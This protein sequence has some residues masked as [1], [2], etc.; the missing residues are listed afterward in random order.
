MVVM[1][2]RYGRQEPVFTTL[3]ALDEPAMSDGADCA[4]LFGSYGVAFMP[5]Q[6]QELGC[7]L[8]MKD[9]GTKAYKT[10][11]ISK[12]RQNGK[13]F[14]A[15]FYALWCASVEGK[16]VLFSAHLGTTVR[17]FYKELEDFI[18][19]NSDFLKALKPGRSSLYRAAGSEGI[20]FANGGMIEFS[21]RTAGGGRGATYDLV[22]FDEAQ[23]LTDAQLEAVKPTMMA[24]KSG[25]SQSIYLGTPPNDEAQ[26]TVFARMHDKCHAGNAD[27]IL[28]MEWSVPEITDPMDKEAW[29]QTNP[30]LGYRVT[31]S[32]ILDAARD[33]S[34]EGF[35]REIL[36][37]WQPVINRTQKINYEQWTAL[38]SKD[39]PDWSVMAYA[40]KFSADGT[41]GAIA[42]CFRPEDGTPFVVVLRH[43]STG[44]SVKWISDYLIEHKDQASMVIIDG[45]AKADALIQK[46]DAGRFPKRRRSIAT[47]GDLVAATSMFVDAIE[48]GDL[49]HTGD[50][51]ALNDAVKQCPKRSIG[52]Y[53]GFGF[54]DTENASAGLIEA[55]ALAYKAAMD[56]KI[57]S[58]KGGARIGGFR[59]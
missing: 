32:S 39:V 47:T 18:K 2:K 11:A 57:K 55:C 33:M 28:W 50:Q 1:A 56:V 59:N 27:G 31:E 20:Y 43:Q 58:K 8:A 42:A 37:W 19:S 9:D 52:K 34:P 13:S 4:S 6:E 17:K 51:E 46:L 35:S 15:R 54:A 3:K 26:G 40:V 45:R 25:D 10:I 41:R 22:I 53:G 24:C 48:G 7:F 30:S 49:A 36:G 23:E 16:N 12:P 5:G 38:A 44:R 14:S 29:Y 21:T